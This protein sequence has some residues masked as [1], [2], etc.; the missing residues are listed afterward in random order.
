MNYPMKM[1]FSIPM[2]TLLSAKVFVVCFLMDIFLKYFSASLV[3]SRI[4]DR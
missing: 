2:P 1:N 4:L 3:N